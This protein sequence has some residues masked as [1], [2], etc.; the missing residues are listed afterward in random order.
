M[1]A[2]LRFYIF[3][4]LICFTVTPLLTIFQLYRGGWNQSIQRKITDKLYHIMLYGVHISMNWFRTQIRLLI[5][6]T[7]K[8]LRYYG[9]IFSLFWFV[10]LVSNSHY[11][12]LGL[13]CMAT[14]FYIFVTGSIWAVNMH[15][16]DIFFLIYTVTD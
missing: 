3:T 15:W 1:S 4:L 8:C 14:Y 16:L 12:Y 5:F 10:L 2:V 9:F 13:I 11:T 6:N 7:V